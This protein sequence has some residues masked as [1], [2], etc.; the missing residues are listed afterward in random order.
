MDIRSFLSRNIFTRLHS[1]K[2]KNHLFSHLRELE[3]TQ[4]LP[5][6][7]LQKRQLDAAKRLLIHAYET[8]DFYKKRFS[9]AGFNP[10]KFD[11]LEQLHDL[12][13]LTKEDIIKNSSAMI[14]K[15]FKKESLLNSCTGGSTGTQ[16][17]FFLDEEGV[18]LKNACA[19]RS[20]KWANWDIGMPIASVW[21]N[22][23]KPNT[24]KAKLRANLIIRAFYLDT[25][26]MTESSMMEFS[27]Q[28]K[29]CTNYVVYGHSHSIF[30]FA[31]FLKQQNI[32]LPSPA[33]IVATSM[34]LMNN[35]RDLI[36]EV[37]RQKVTDRYGCEEVSLIASE[38]EIHNGMHINI[39]HLVVEFI[40]QNGNSA[41]PGEEGR[42][43]T[44]DLTNFG[45]P[46]IRYE[47]GDVG[48]PS[49]RIC[50]CGR[51]LPMME[52][53]TGRTADFLIRVDGSRVA[54]VSLIERLLTNIAGI[55]QMQI[56]QNQK[57]NLLIR[58]VKDNSFSDKKTLDPF[59][60]EFNEI[61]PGT[62]LNIEYTDKIS[63]EPNGKY[64]FSICNI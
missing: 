9:D 19:R 3:R 56:V 12:P 14:S 45:M 50:K 17:H 38:C 4:W 46:F 51:N 30:V 53:I 21:G 57:D 24:Y 23:K 60:K 27:E 15:S 39:D 42:I 32:I 10:L 55:H 26:N 33:G 43:I 13:I 59:K 25:M 58:I 22:P 18:N 11:H 62:L 20:N 29:K 54:G 41:L 52:S 31:E 8:T 40:K 34:M 36:E 49:N 28:I 2:E 16:L 5:L 47:V 6:K 48:I 35:E 63:Q 44:T 61:F 7:E 1:Y 64:R 37:F